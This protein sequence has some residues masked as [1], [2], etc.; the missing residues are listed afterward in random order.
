M[1][2]NVNCTKFNPGIFNK[3]IFSACLDFGF[4]IETDVTSGNSDFRSLQDVVLEYFTKTST[5]S[6][7]ISSV[8][9]LI[10][11]CSLW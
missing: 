5:S 10:K 7:C 4:A 1:S 3:T 8:K 6:F 2:Q 11:N 9:V